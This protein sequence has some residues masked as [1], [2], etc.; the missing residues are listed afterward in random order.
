MDLLK[1]I[2][3]KRTIL[4]LMLLIFIVGCTET[5]IKKTI[6]E[7]TYTNIE[8]ESVSKEPE[9]EQVKTESQEIIP[10]WKLG[11]TAIAGKYADADI[12]ALGDGRYRMYYSAEPE[13]PGFQG[14]VY[15][16][17]SSDGINW[18]QEAG[19]RRTWSTFPSV[20][21]LSDG[22]YRMY[23]QNAEEI[24]S[25]VSSDGLSW[26]DE[27]GARMDGANSAGLVLENVAA[28]TVIE[29]NG[30]YIMVYR[31]TINQ[32]YAAD[33]P[34]SNTQLFLWA[35]SQDGK[36]FEKKGIVLDSRNE[37]FMGLLDGPELVKWDDGSIR[38]YFWSYAGV[39]YVAFDGQKF[40]DD[41]KFAYGSVSSDPLAKFPPNPPGD[42]TL[43]KIGGKWFMYYGQHTQ[44]IYYATLGE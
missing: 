23:F 18:Q 5:E 29:S 30:Q 2:N 27:Q 25:A 42:P 3:M 15:S 4:I 36:A 17:V 6:P 8:K 34:N 40:S 22:S 38:L 20:I 10:A 35:A 43:A 19:T 7:Q 32:R 16:A 28:P 13:L 39:Y 14:Q 1:N 11:G 33:V 21:K 44:G 24:K 31:G 41:A 12:I 9:K 37:K 26:Q